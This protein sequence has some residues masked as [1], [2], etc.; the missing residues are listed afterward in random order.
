MDSN[1]KGI[2]FALSHSFVCLGQTESSCSWKAAR[3]SGVWRT[4]ECG[5]SLAS[6]GS[7]M[8]TFQKHLP[9]WPASLCG[10]AE[11]VHE[12]NLVPSVHTWMHAC[13]HAWECW[14]VKT[15]NNMQPVSVRTC[16]R[17]QAVCVYCCTVYCLNEHFDSFENKIYELRR[18]WFSI[19]QYPLQCH[20]C[21]EIS[22]FETTNAG[23][24]LWS[25]LWKFL[26]SGR[27]SIHHLL[28]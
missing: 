22:F 24:H 3:Q 25:C 23:M 2:S 13:M 8:R 15:S 6:Q 11:S 21:S 12:C 20:I 1:S 18:W 28:E 27:R 7:I 9:N 19:N 16:R 4:V 17:S 14:F 5:G 10:W 26:C